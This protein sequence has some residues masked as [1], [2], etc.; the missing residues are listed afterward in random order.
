[1][2][3]IERVGVRDMLSKGISYEASASKSL[4]LL[5]LD[6]GAVLIDHQVQMA[7]YNRICGNLP[8]NLMSR[9][10]NTYCC[11][12][13]TSLLPLSFLLKRRKLV[14]DELVMLLCDIAG[15][16]LD[17]GGFLLDDGCYVVDADYIFI[18]PENLKIFMLYVPVEKPDNDVTEPDKI[19][20]VPGRVDTTMQFRNFVLEVMLERANITE[21]KNDDF[22]QRILVYIRNENYGI[23]G[24][25]AM[26]RGLLQERN[27]EF[28]KQD[29]DDKSS[30]IRV[31]DESLYGSSKAGGVKDKKY[32]LKDFFTSLSGKFNKSEKAENKCSGVLL[33]AESE[34]GTVKATDNAPGKAPDNAPLR[35][36]GKT[37]LL[38][39]KISSI[40]VLQSRSGGEFNDIPIEK[41]EVIIGRLEGQVD[42]ICNNPA[43]GKV[44]AQITKGI[45]GTYCIKDL[46]S[47]NGTFINCTR[48][49]CNTDYELKDGDQV[50]L[51][52]SEYIFL[53]NPCRSE[54]SSA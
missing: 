23:R 50:N 14:R 8:F 44:H 27:P 40:P 5:K 10:G 21:C 35:T 45:D 2:R 1:M 41:P 12:D 36:G 22:Y 33:G 9:A 39:T 51:A 43:I 53:I 13:I 15:N 31:V 46:N 42:H 30:I 11:Y 37:V 25:T 54:I 49:T 6:E 52:N 29:Q 24:F 19:P 7:A 47:V 16:L 34:E 32:G 3:S 48:V 28:E 26:L 38:N 4:L 18:D 17:C 20:A